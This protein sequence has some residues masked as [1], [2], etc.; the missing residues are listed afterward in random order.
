MRA[1][2]MWH[3]R[4]ARE[5]RML[6]IGGA[7]AAVLLFVALVWLPL[8]RAHARLEQ[9]LPQLRQSIA[10]LERQAQEVQR[11][12]AIPAANASSA[13]GTTPPLA[14]AQVSTP[15]PGRLRVVANDIAFTALVDWLTAVQAAQG[16]H[17]ESAHVEAL[18]A[19]GRVRADVTLA[20][21]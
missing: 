7:I 19:T 11:L 10:A 6:A 4:P 17:V 2:E 21:S 5:Q 14:G 15:A 18:P 1:L 12:R 3:A 8:A 13:A 9:Q 20:R 16:V